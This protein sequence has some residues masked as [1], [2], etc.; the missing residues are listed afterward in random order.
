MND[1]T[2]NNYFSIKNVITTAAIG[3]FL[4]MFA[5]FIQGMYSE[6]QEENSMKAAFSGEISALLSLVKEREILESVKEAEQNIELSGD[7]KFPDFRV[8]NP[9]IY[10]HVYPSLASKLGSL[11]APLSNKLAEFYTHVYFTIDELIWMADANTKASQITKK[12]ALLEL[13]Q[14]HAILSKTI[15]EGDALISEIDS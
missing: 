11:N 9:E 2:S 12:Q 15:K 14:F 8:S 3:I 6:Y 4:T 7:V 5:Q 1:T 10:I 13:Q